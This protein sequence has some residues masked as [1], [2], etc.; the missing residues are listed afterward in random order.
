[1]GISRSGTESLRE[2]LLKLG[3][4]HTYHGWDTILPPPSQLEAWY[5][6]ATRKYSA[7]AE[8]IK[9]EDFD[10]I[11]GHCVAI[12]DLPAAFFAKE[13]IAA[14]PE[15]KVIL[16][17]RKDVDA[18]YQ[19]FDATMG[20]FDRNPVDFDW[21]CS[22]FCSDLFW[23]RQSMSRAQVPLFF[24]GSFARNGKEVYREHSEAIR[25]LGLPKDKLLE[26]HVNDGWGPLCEFLGKEV[27]REPFPEGNTPQD[28]LE[29]IGAAMQ[30][31]HARARKNML[32]SGAGLA[33]AISLA[34]WAAL[35]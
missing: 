34:K 18:W 4:N 21:L 35:K 30:S 23:I 25:N 12:T 28:W 9:A 19:S 26:W 6:L 16:N 10:R 5:Y 20:V 14:Y 3:Y 8:P 2:A 32:L 27:P 24:R 17:V 31:Y 15:A 13:L 7:S 29:R 11:I 22:W 33:V 1:M